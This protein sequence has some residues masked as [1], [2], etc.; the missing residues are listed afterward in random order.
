MGL[1][2]L[3]GGFTPP[4]PS[5]STGHYP[6]PGV[7]AFKQLPQHTHEGL[8]FWGCFVGERPASRQPRVC[9][10]A[11]MSSSTVWLVPCG[12]RVS[13]SKQYEQQPEMKRNQWPPVGARAPSRPPPTT[14]RFGA[15]RC[16]P[17]HCLWY[18]LPNPG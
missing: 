17:A 15:S 14:A 10:E 1:S 2:L 11:G 5:P 9:E 8:A 18:F 3:S 13:C 16:S 6:G 7:E 4:L 12:E